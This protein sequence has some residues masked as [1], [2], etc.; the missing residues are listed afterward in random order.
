MS[1]AQNTPP[2]QTDQAELREEVAQA[3]CDHEEKRQVAWLVEWPASK[4][5]PVRYW[6]ATDGHMLDPHEATWLAR[7]QDAEAVIKRDRLHAG[8][9][10][11]EHV[12]GL[13]LPIKGSDDVG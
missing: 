4:Q 8:A 7:R 10:P 13:S 1:P 3:I 2:P 12:F 6:H 9:R 5:M 11:V